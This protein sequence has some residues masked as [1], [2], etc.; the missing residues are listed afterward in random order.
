MYA[1][2]HVTSTPVL[3]PLLTLDKEEIVKKAKA[4][5]TYDVSIQPFEDCCTIF[6]PKNPVT[7]PDFDKVEKYEDGFDFE[8]LVQEAVDGIET[9][10][11]TKDYQSDKDTETQALA[12]DLF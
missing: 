3:R 1:I 7:E 8:P 5:G 12:D 10:T 9:L 2:N 4:I 11:I 6:T